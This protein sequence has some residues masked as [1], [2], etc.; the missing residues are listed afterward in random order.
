MKIPESL[1][2]IY[3]QAID[4]GWKVTRTR[5][6]HLRWTNPNGEICFTASTPSDSI[7]NKRN[8]VALLRRHGLKLD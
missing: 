8:V 1:R 7:R 2:P 6:Q 4:Q 5:N 3:K